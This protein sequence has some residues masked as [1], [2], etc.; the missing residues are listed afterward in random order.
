MVDPVVEVV[1]TR[2][3]PGLDP[4]LVVL[5]VAVDGEVTRVETAGMRAERRLADGEDAV[6]GDAHEVGVAAQV[7]DDALDG[8]DRTPARR[9]RAPHVLEQRRVQRDVAGAVGDRRVQQR[10]VGHE[11]REQADLAERVSRRARTPSFASIDDPAIER[12]T[13][14]G[15]PRAAASSRC[16]NAR[17]DQC[18]TST[19]PR[20]VRAAEDRVRREVRERV[21]RVAGDDL[22]D[23]PAVGRTACPRLDRL[24]MT[25]VNP[26]SRP[27]HWRTTSRAAAVQRVWPTKRWSVSP[28]RTCSATASRKD[29]TLV[30]HR[31]TP[32]PVRAR[33]R[34][35]AARCQPW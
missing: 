32:T 16:E 27:H 34:R 31:R 3:R 26:G 11:R 15:S 8:D 17:N 30:G 21:A 33:G 9:E 23:E 4:E 29:G 12:V 35:G 25:S 19:S 28:A 1:A 22:A 6:R 5:A 18:S 20:S 14:A 24:S 2:R 13:I 7:V 10:D